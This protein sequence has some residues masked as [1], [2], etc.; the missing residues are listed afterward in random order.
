LLFF[1]SPCI[2]LSFSF[3]S[4]LCVWHDFSELSSILTN[5]VFLI[6]SLL[7]LYSFSILLLSKIPQLA[8]I[9][10]A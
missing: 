1:V 7:W 5:L 3:S 10:S 8:T 2:F 6:F 9:P 4:S